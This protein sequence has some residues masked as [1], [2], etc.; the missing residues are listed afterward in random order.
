MKLHICYIQRRN[1][2]RTQHGGKKI[3]KPK[4]HQILKY[5]SLKTLTRH[6]NFYYLQNKNKNTNK[7]H[8][9]LFSIFFFLDGTQTFI[10]YKIKIKT[11]IRPTNFY[12]IQNKIK[13]IR[14][15]LEKF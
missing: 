2:K 10:P 8:K 4:Q 12:S 13:I 9:L 1:Y 7:T 14:P 5:G 15:Q 11:L 6:T 3:A